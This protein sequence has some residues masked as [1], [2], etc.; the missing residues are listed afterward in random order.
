MASALDL[1][2]VAEGIERPEQARALSD[3]GCLTGQGYLFSRPQP[4]SVML[5]ALVDRRPAACASQVSAQGHGAGRPGVP[6]QAP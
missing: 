1:D 3:A 6:Q 4:L 2:V 5:D